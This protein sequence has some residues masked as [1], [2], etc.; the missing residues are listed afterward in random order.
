[1]K[2]SRRTFSFFYENTSPAFFS[3]TISGV[4]GL[5]I[6][7]AYSSG[8]DGGGGRGCS[9]IIKSRSLTRYDDGDDDDASRVPGPRP[10]RTGSRQSSGVLKPPV[11]G[12]K[13]I[14]MTNLTLRFFFF[15]L[16]IIPTSVAK[17]K[18]TCGLELYD[19]GIVPLRRSS[20]A[21]N[22][23]HTRGAATAN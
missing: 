20:L 16:I 15:L 17:T 12:P 2:I 23:T 14:I 8:I 21:V 18:R 7:G 22:A 5:F 11:T 1:M 13:R 19:L 9:L 10:L 6:L 4:F 3:K